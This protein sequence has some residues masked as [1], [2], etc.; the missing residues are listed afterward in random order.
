MGDRLWGRN[1]RFTFIL[2]MYVSNSENEGKKTKEKN[3]ESTLVVGT[4]LSMTEGQS[5]SCFTRIITSIISCEYPLMLRNSGPMFPPAYEIDSRGGGQD[6]Q[7]LIFSK[8]ISALA[9]I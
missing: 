3:L 5:F 6:T 7:K 2:P 1:S 9:N 8:G 4:H